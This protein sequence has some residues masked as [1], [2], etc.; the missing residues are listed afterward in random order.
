MCKSAPILKSL[1]IISIIGDRIA[2]FMYKTDIVKFIKLL[3]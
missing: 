3:R 1:N 2:G